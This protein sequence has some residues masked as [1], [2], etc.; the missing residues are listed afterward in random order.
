MCVCV[1]EDRMPPKVLANNELAVMEGSARKITTEY[2][3]ATDVDS[4]PA[5]LVFAITQQPMLGHI[6]FAEDPVS[7]ILF[8]FLYI[9]SDFRWADFTL[10]LL[11]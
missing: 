7:P 4:E 6:A 1:T 11:L 3:S 2:L 10:A 5:D 8:Y 9:F